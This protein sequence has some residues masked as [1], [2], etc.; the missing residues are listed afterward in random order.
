MYLLYHFVM[1]GCL[2]VVEGGVHAHG[3]E[4]EICLGFLE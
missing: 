4:V 3:V 2:D 1:Y